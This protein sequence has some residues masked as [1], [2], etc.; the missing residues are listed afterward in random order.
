MGRVITGRDPITD[1]KVAGMDR[2]SFIFFYC[3]KQEP[4]PFRSWCSP[5]VLF[6]Q[7]VSEECLC[8][9]YLIRSAAD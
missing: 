8:R 2:F 9:M 1:D 3:W 4:C 7:V 6:V 5:L